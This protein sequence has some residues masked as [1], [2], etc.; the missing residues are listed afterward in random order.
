[1]LLEKEAEYIGSKSKNEVEIWS[2]ANYSIREGLQRQN[3]KE[4]LKM[5]QLNTFKES[6]F[7]SN[8]MVN[9]L[10]SVFFNEWSRS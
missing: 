3:N 2:F 7:R 4:A 10:L 5:I 1:M 6:V 8:E 9:R